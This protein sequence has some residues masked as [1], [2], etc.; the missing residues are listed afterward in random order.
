MLPYS[1]NAG[2]TALS[3]TIRA[4]ARDGSAGRAIVGV[5]TVSVRVTTPASASRRSI[6]S[7]AAGVQSRV[8]LMTTSAAMSDLGFGPEH[9]A[10]VLNDRAQRH[11]GGHADG[12]ADEEEQQAAPCRARLADRHLQHEPHTCSTTRPSRRTSRESAIAASSASCVTRTI[13]VP[14]A[15]WML[16]QQLEDVAPGR[17]VEIAGRL[18]G[19]HDRRIVRERTRQ[20]DPLLLAAGQL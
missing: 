4:T 5:E 11:D 13:V 1:G 19:Q 9:L 16:A 18:V 15:R 20:R 8:V 3:S 17:R 7:L 2:W 14:R 6:I 10:H 12:D